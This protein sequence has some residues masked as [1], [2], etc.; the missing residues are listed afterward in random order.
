[1]DVP[2]SVYAATVSEG[3]MY[4]FK[5]DCPIG[6][7]DHIHVCIKRGDTVFLFATGSSQVEKAI[8][9]ASLLGY[10]LNTYPVFTKN[11]TNKLNKEMTYIDCN[12][13]IET[14]QKEFCELIQNG[15]V[16]ELPGTF[17]TD[18]LALILNGVKCSKLV[19]ARIKDML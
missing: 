2:S 4:F 12:S 9:R 6:V 10:D 14:S 7:S 3:K 19:E 1:M 15:K 13:P 17:D 18:S 5:S 11:D 8:T 16:Y